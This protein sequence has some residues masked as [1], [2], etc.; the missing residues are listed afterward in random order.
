M[1]EEKLKRYEAENKRKEEKNE[2]LMT[3]IRML[4]DALI[5]ERNEKQVIL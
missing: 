4:K 2:A 5:V 1:R 3:E